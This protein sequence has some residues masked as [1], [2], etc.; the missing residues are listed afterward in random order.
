MCTKVLKVLKVL[1]EGAKD[2]RRAQGSLKDKSV[3]LRNKSSV[4]FD[5]VGVLEVLK[6][7]RC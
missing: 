2:V 5:R 7:R 6:V 4:L 1:K 3:S